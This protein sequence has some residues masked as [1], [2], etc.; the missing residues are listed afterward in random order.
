MHPYFVK[1][2]LGVFLY[3][4]PLEGWEALHGASGGLGSHLGVV[5]SCVQGSSACLLPVARSAADARVM[6]EALET[7]TDGAVLRTEDP[8]QV[9]KGPCWGQPCTWRYR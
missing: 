4:C 5:L 2:P 8:A 3:A 1:P 9:R 6:L 7:G